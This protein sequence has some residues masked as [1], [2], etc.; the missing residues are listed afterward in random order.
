ML[1]TNVLKSTSQPKSFDLLSKLSQTPLYALHCRSLHT[2]TGTKALFTTTSPVS[3]FFR[4]ASHYSKTETS[5]RGLGL[6]TPETSLLSRNFS[7]DS[8]R[9]IKCSIEKNNRRIFDE[10]TIQFLE[11]IFNKSSCRSD[12][13]GL[14]ALGYNSPNDFP[15][16]ERKWWVALQFKM[17]SGLRDIKEHEY[18]LLDGSSLKTFDEEIVKECAQEEI[19]NRMLPFKIH[20]IEELADLMLKI[21]A[22]LAMKLSEN[23]LFSNDMSQ[24]QIKRLSAMVTYKIIDK[25]S[26]TVDPELIKLNPG[27]FYLNW[28]DLFKHISFM[29]PA[30]LDRVISGSSEKLRKK[31]ERLT[32]TNFK[33]T[34][35]II[36]SLIDII[37]SELKSTVL[38]SKK[39]R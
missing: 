5:L 14:F 1:I 33:G 10:T 6:H 12:T 31:W 17:L 15:A 35:F 7:S 16:Q 21:Q 23:K 38:S 22:E 24:D 3:K 30:C 36:D 4:S 39:V 9:T 20:C 37:R 26:E 25:F 29:T 27:S 32:D 18:G 13:Y 11:D 2:M 19:A 8:T 34:L 28:G